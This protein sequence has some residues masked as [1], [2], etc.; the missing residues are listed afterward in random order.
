M[1]KDSCDKCG[2]PHPRCNGHV[3]NGA[4]AGQ[5]CMRQPKDGGLVC[6]F[7]GGASPQ[8]EAARLR[9]VALRD[10]KSALGQIGIP[11]P[12]TGVEEAVQAALDAAHGQLMGTTL[13]LLNADEG[14]ERLEAFADL[15]DRAISRLATV[16]KAAADMGVAERRTKLAETQSV[17]VAHV[18]REIVNRLGLTPE[19]R[20]AFPSIARE[21]LTQLPGA[22]IDVSEVEA[23]G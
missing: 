6:R 13:L 19:Q 14:D 20:A 1:A 17:M 7:C 2:Q 18:L 21:V 23:G 4:R 15:H 8:V 22:P 9:R 5:P 16:G 11:I 10:A 3:R 12:D